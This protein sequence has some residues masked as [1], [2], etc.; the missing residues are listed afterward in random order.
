M[1]VCKFTDTQMYIN[2]H[3]EISYL[4]VYSWSI[5]QRIWKES[6]TLGCLQGEKPVGWLEDR[7]G[8]IF[9]FTFVTT[10]V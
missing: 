7:S 6:A 5:F 10:E 8:K 9:F 4:R 2:I 3:K 1:P